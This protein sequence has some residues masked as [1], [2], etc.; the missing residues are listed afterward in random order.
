MVTP[1]VPARSFT[2]LVHGASLEEVRRYM[3]ALLLD[4]AG[5]ATGPEVIT[6]L[7]SVAG[8]MRQ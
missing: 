5:R 6:T 7:A 3:R 8:R 4:R 2:A 1:H